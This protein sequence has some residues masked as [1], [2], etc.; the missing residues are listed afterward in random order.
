M[1]KC[2]KILLKY[3]DFLLLS[4]LYHIKLNIFGFKDKL[5]HLKNFENL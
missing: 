1:Q 2:L 5:R 3:G 4:A